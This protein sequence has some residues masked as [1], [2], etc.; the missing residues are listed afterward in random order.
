[1]TSYH[2]QSPALSLS[3]QPEDQTPDGLNAFNSIKT[4]L[5]PGSTVSADA[6]ASSV[7]AT[8]LPTSLDPEQKADALWSL[9]NVLIGMAKQIPH[10]HPALVKLVRVVDRLAR[11]TKTTVT[12]QAGDEETVDRLHMLGWSLRDIFGPPEFTSTRGPPSQAEK[13]AYLSTQAFIALLWSGDLIEGWDFALW[14]LR[15]ALEEK[16]QQSEEEKLLVAAAALWVIHGGPRIWQLVVDTP[17][18]A[19]SDQRTL[20][21]GSKFDGPG[22]YSVQRW[23]YW[24]RAFEEHAGEDDMTGRLAKRAVAVMKGLGGDV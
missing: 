14:Q 24:L 13:D 15:S 9:Y 1:M 5:E 2:A 7:V 23:E 8:M 10:D 17:E 20:R 16:A 12:Q 3:S 11:S 21:P 6:T 22:G 19:G 18:Y 4:F